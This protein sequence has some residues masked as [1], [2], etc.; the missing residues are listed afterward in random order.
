MRYEENFI[1]VA[2]CR[3]DCNDRLPQ[4]KQSKQHANGYA[5]DDAV[6]SPRHS[7]YRAMEEMFEIR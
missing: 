2:V 6:P 1:I 4:Y 5:A 3:Y 7:E